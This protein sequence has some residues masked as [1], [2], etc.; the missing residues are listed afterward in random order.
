VSV[1]SRWWRE[2]ANPPVEQSTAGVNAV[3]TTPTPLAMSV[4]SAGLCC[5]V[6]HQLAAASPA[7][8]ANLDHFQESEFQTPNGDPVRVARLP[9]H[10]AWGA[11]RLARW[12]QLAVLD[13]LAKLPGASVDRSTGKADGEFSAEDCALLV[14]TAQPEDADE[15]RQTLQEVIDQALLSLQRTWHTDSAIFGLGRAGLGAVLKHANALLHSRAGPKHVLLVGVDSL[16]TARLV[17]RLLGQQRLQVPGNNDGFF[18]GEAAAALLLR[19]PDP[20]ASALTLHATA[21]SQELALWDGEIPN[22]GEALTAVV[23][24]ACEAAGLA[25]AQLGLRVSDANGEGHLTREGT[26]A[27][28]RLRFGA[29]ALPHLTPAGSL[30]DVGAAFGV[31]ALAYLWHRVQQPNRPLDWPAQPRWHAVLHAAND[32]GWRCAVVAELHMA[33]PDVGTLF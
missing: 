6:G 19:C 14:L 20:A 8:L 15:G 30:G 12:V 32:N 10:N 17:G 11:R 2:P 33:R 26:L 5:A 1:A 22:R 27:F 21:S 25:P 9:G 29:S 24:A 28:T 18:P 16:L 13:A 3:Q 31:A 7:L 23:R 4:V